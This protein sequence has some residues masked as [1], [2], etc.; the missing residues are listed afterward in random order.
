MLA[1]PAD[2]LLIFN[3]TE[4]SLLAAP[5]YN[6]NP[7]QVGYTNFAFFI[8]GLIGVATGGPLS[9]W[10]A[11]RATRRNNGIREAEQRLPALIPFSILTVILHVVGGLATQRHWSWPILL[12]FGYGL[13]GLSVTT[14]PTI[15]IAYAIDCFKPISGEIMIIAT[16]FKNTVS[17]VPSPFPRLSLTL[18]NY[19]R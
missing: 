10:V 12:V 15:A 16:I 4:S 2:V 19:D 9:D 14:V 7:G 8:G 18:E 17:F 1:G 11:K 5:P 6:F 3:L 13:S